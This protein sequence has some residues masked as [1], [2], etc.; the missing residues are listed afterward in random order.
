MIIH[1]AITIMN[2]I[3][4]MLQLS[5]YYDCF[6]PNAEH[7]FAFGFFVKNMLDFCII[8]QYSKVRCL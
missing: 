1:G 7:D 3:M 5:N 6:S 8:V 2:M 4:Y